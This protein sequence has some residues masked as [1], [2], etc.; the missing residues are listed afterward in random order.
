MQPARVSGVGKIGR[1]NLVNG[2][3]DLVII[4]IRDAQQEID[5]EKNEIQWAESYE[6][7][8]IAYRSNGYTTMDWLCTCSVEFGCDGDKDRRYH[9]LKGQKAGKVMK[10]RQGVLEDEAILLVGRNMNSEL[11]IKS[12]EA[13]I[14]AIKKGGLLIGRKK[15]GGGFAYE[16]PDGRLEVC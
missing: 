3:R 2:L 16:M 4:M 1:I 15:R 10:P 12:L 13:M 5:M 8:A 7:G 9:M 6:G 14:E 11:V